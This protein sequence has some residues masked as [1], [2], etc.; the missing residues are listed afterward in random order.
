MTRIG[1]YAVERRLG[2]GGMAEVF[3]AKV[4]GAEGFSAPVAIK[5]VL[6][7][8]SDQPDFAAMFIS[9]AK[10]SARLRHPNIVSV[11]DFKRDEEHGLFLVMELVEGKDL[12][13]L[14]AT[15]M[16][17][18][19]LA[20]YI[21][22]Q[23]LRGLGYAHNP[24]RQ[25]DGIRGIIHR[26]ISPQNVLLSWE[27]Q[28]KISDFGIAKSRE[29]TQAAASVMIKG[30]P[31]YMSPEQADG[32][33]LDGRS[34][35]FAVGIM[36][37][38]MLTGHALFQGSSTQEIFVALLMSPIRAPT[39]LRPDLPADVCAVAMRLLEK[40]V[41]RRYATAEAAVKDLLACVDFPRDGCTELA[42]VAQTRFLSPS[43]VPTIVASQPPRVRIGAPA[44]SAATLRLG[45]WPVRKLWLLF[46][47]VL[48]AATAAAV[49]VSALFTGRGPA[50]VL[51]VAPA[52]VDQPDE[53]TRAAGVPP[54]S[55]TAAI[56]PASAAPAAAA[57]V[58]SPAAAPESKQMRK[59]RQYPVPAEAPRSGIVEVHF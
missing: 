56:P 28:V 4:V 36:L 25:D 18:I 6:P 19:S 55:N 11:L 24:P 48:I 29:A 23:V 3:L 58:S 39:V 31:A 43:Q 35:L 59:K 2:G 54:P 5:R 51:P 30:K 32:R 42:I 41:E 50:R 45:G 14:L 7:G 49:G 47:F 33:P 1:E 37:W 34:D 21:T 13:Q 17:P 40:N 38:E 22:T 10:L 12:A 57:P 9:E 44:R 16:I 20:I 53:P 8:F 15:G 27:G 52:A 26:D 46:L